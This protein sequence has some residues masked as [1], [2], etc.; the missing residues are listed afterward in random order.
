VESFRNLKELWAN[1]LNKKTK[2]KENSLMKD[3]WTNE[4]QRLGDEIIHL[5]NTLQK[6]KE[7][8]K[9]RENHL[10]MLEENITLK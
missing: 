8:I 9:D 6:M 1:S 7:S 10:K 5:N 4:V 2:S 3:K